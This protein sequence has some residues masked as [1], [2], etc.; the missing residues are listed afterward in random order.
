M[1]YYYKAN[2]LNK[3]IFQFAC[4]PKTNTPAATCVR[5]PSYFPPGLY[6]IVYPSGR[7]GGPGELIL[8]LKERWA[9]VKVFPAGCDIYFKSLSLFLAFLHKPFQVCQ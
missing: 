4:K 2:V 3:P 8:F 5:V 6:S 7:A 1:C 9:A